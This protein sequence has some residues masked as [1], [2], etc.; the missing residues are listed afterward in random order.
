MVF[1]GICEYGIGNTEWKSTGGNGSE[2][3]DDEGDEEEIK[4]VN[5][6]RIEEQ[7]TDERMSCLVSSMSV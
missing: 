5:S 7:T 6:R 2:E 1:N 3:D 4:D